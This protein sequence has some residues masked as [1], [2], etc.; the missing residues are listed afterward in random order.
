MKITA[1]CPRF[2]G[3]CVRGGYR[4]Y[5]R[6]RGGTKPC[7]ALPPR[8]AERADRFAA[9]PRRS[10]A[11][12]QFGSAY[13]PLTVVVN[14]DGTSGFEFDGVLGAEALERVLAVFVRTDG[15]LAMETVPQEAE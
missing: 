13:I 15:P 11:F 8:R 4:L 5:R 12:G 3:V 2:D 14:A 9:E 1:G 7:K 6:Q 10:S